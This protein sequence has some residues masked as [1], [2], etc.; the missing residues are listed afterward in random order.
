MKLIVVRTPVH[1]LLTWTSFAFFEF[2]QRKNQILVRPQ[3]YL[4]IIHL[5]LIPS[6]FRIFHRPPLLLVR[7]R[8]A[9]S[10]YVVSML[11]YCLMFYLLIR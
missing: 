9:L 2:N 10:Y 1:T 11:L 8:D 4:K 6:S 5:W 3:K 7:C